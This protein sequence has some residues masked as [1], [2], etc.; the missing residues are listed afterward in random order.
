MFQA[1][2]PVYFMS[3]LLHNQVYP[4]TVRLFSIFCQLYFKL[5]ICIKSTIKNLKPSFQYPTNQTSAFKYFIKPFSTLLSPIS[6]QKHLQF[7]SLDQ[8]VENETVCAMIAVQIDRIVG[9]SRLCARAGF[10]IATGQ[11]GCSLMRYGPPAA[12]VLLYHLE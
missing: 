8:T 6:L 1:K 9:T 10:E 5:K 4:A 12:P 2:P 7:N 11:L 3:R